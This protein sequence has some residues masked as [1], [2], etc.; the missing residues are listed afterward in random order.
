M[1]HDKYEPCKGRK[2]SLNVLADHYSALYPKDYTM[3]L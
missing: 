3:T 1:L 2:V